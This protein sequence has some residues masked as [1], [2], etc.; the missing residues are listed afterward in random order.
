MSGS[1]VHVIAQTLSPADI[2]GLAK[3]AV[4]DIP[5]VTAAGVLQ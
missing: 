4:T 1:D 2:S 3:H 5:I